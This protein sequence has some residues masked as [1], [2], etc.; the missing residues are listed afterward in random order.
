[1]PLQIEK[2]GSM[3]LQLILLQICSSIDLSL[4]S[5]T[6]SR[7]H[8][9]VPFLILCPATQM[10]GWFAGEEACVLSGCYKMRRAAAACAA[11][12][13]SKQ[14]QEAWPGV[15]MRQAGVRTEDLDF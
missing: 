3:P 7:W 10:A 6:L 1:M 14:G 4:S 11:R 8:T 13:C 2:S 9:V 5:S 12:K 15:W